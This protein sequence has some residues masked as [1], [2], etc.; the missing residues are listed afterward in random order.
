MKSLEDLE[1]VESLSAADKAEYARIQQE[2]TECEEA[3]SSLEKGRLGVYKARNYRY[4][5]D[6]EIPYQRIGEFSEEGF[7]LGP[8]KTPLLFEAS[9]V[10]K[11]DTKFFCT[12]IDCATYVVGSTAQT[13]TPIVS[14]LKPYDRIIYL[15]FEWAVRDTG[16]DRAWQ[17]QFLPMS[18]LKTNRINPLVLAAPTVVS[19]GSELVLSCQV[20]YMLF[21]PGQGLFSD[22]K[23]FMLQFSFSGY[24][25]SAS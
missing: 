8:S 25:V 22:I 3:I 14:A 23:N 16:S 21:F 5:L 4:V 6:L 18:I 7:F 17:N 20:N 12:Y 24:E 15:N 11:K 19:G 2:I 9:T 13:N 10:V 1:K